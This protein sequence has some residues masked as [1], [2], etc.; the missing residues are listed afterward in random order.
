VASSVG[1]VLDTS[2]S[3]RNALATAKAAT[4]TF[5]KA[6]NPEDEFLLLTVSTEPDTLSGFTRDPAALDASVDAAKSGGMTALIDTVYLG[7]TSMHKAIRPRR[8]LLILSD[9]MDN[10]SHLSKKK[11][12]RIA[13]E[14]DVQVY[15]IILQGELGGG[16]PLTLP[17][18]PS[19]IAKPGDQHRE[20]EGPALLEELAEK[21]GGES[22]YIGFTGAPVSLSP[23]LEDVAHRLGHQYLLT[24][25]ARPPKKA[26]LQPVKIR[27]EV[28][29]ADLVAAHE[30]YVP[31]RP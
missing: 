7:L 3:M 8:A 19:M 31:A 17:Y 20:P 15:T 14:A 5:L 2:G 18:R 27:T 16:T 28:P 29:N 13:I 10:H 1:V 11:L 30:V 22:Y 12:I 23:Y 6:A 25:L 26:G 21:T 4:H 24:F 9:G